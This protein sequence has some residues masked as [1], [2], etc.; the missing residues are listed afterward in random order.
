[1]IDEVDVNDTENYI[2]SDQ[3][4]EVAQQA[5]T[6]VGDAEAG[7]INVQQSYGAV[8][9]GNGFDDSGRCLLYTF[10]CV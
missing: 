7:I 1:M 3:L 2:V 8:A 10:R 9:D 6:F 5:G 4:I